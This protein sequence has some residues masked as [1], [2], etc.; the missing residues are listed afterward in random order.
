MTR[1]GNLR[2][3][4]TIRTI[5]DF[6]SFL[7]IISSMCDA[8]TVWSK[9]KHLT[10]QQRFL[11]HSSYLFSSFIGSLQA[12][13]C[14]YT[15]RCCVRLLVMQ[16]HLQRSPR[17]PSWIKG[18]LLHYA[19]LRCLSDRT[20][21]TDVQLSYCVVCIQRLTK[22]LHCSRSESHQIE[23]RHSAGYHLYMLRRL[24]R[25]PVMSR[26]LLS[27][28]YVVWSKQLVSVDVNGSVSDYHQKHSVGFRLSVIWIKLYYKIGPVAVCSSS[29]DWSIGHLLTCTQ[30]NCS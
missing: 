12:A 7:N 19:T 1:V 20:C 21:A 25:C 30:H 6:L 16:F 24:C 28:R 22:L 10:F 5:N 26:Q 15:G 9:G 4:F 23:T 17:H 8:S 11:Y 29:G 3:K 18:I 2:K 27:S 13:W 14:F